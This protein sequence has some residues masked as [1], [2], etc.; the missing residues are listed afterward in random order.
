MNQAGFLVLHDDFVHP[1]NTRPLHDLVHITEKEKRVAEDLIRK[2]YLKK[3]SCRNLEKIR[4]N[5]F[6]ELDVPAKGV[7]T[8]SSNIECQRYEVTPVRSSNVYLGNKKFLG[9]N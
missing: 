4:R 6:W 2:R 5:V 3:K 8:L 9:C 7:S 1:T